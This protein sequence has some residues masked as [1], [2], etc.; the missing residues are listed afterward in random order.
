MYPHVHVYTLCCAIA[1]GD[2]LDIWLVNE[3]QLMGR[4][5]AGGRLHGFIKG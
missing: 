5:L 3:G 1:S 4:M 2:L